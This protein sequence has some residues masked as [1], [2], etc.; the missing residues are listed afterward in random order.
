[1]EEL[2]YEFR[3]EMG[4]PGRRYFRK[5][6]SYPREFNVHVVE[7][8]GGLWRSNLAFRDYLRE[9]PEAIKEYGALKR[10]LVSKPGGG[11]LDQ[12][13]AGKAAFIAEIVRRRGAAG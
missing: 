11:E 3:G 12:Y 1:M 10:R 6:T 8:D 5:G 13:A 4:V 7:F 9:H 2:G